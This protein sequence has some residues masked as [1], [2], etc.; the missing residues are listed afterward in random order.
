MRWSEASHCEYDGKSM[1]TDT[2]TS[3]LAYYTKWKEENLICLCDRKKWWQLYDWMFHS[4]NVLQVRK[5]IEEPCN[6]AKLILCLPTLKW[7]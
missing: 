4:R 1:E 5:D 3:E 6:F 2:T 7:A